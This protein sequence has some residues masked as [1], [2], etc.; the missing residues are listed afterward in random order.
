MP[1]STNDTIPC[2]DR[3]LV[4]TDFSAAS[5]AACRTAIDTCLALRASLLI[6]HVFH[7]V[8]A[9]SPDGGGKK[10]E[11][12]RLKTGAGGQEERGQVSEAKLLYDKC[13]E[14]LE[15]LRLQ[16]LQA[17]VDCETILG[18]GNPTATILKTISAKKIDLAIMGR[19]RCTAWN[20][21]SSIRRPR[22]CCARRLARS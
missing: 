14:S 4:A 16:A 3:L 18:S 1:T 22:R 7:P 10:P 9:G 11:T 5:Q 19:A 13:L 20:A 15:E 21:S 12:G 17:G 8:E 2:F 6:L